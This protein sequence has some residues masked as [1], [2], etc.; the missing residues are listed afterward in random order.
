MIYDVVIGLSN[1]QDDNARVLHIGVDE[2]VPGLDIGFRLFFISDGDQ[3]GK[4]HNG[5]M[6]AC[7][8]TQR[9][10]ENISS[11]CRPDDRIT[12]VSDSH[13]RSSFGNDLREF[14]KD[15]DV[16]CEGNQLHP[17]IL[18]SQ[19]RWDSSICIKS[20]VCVRMVSVANLVHTPSFLGTGRPVMPSRTELFSAGSS[21]T[22]NQQAKDE[23]Q[24]IHIPKSVNP[25]SVA[26]LHLRK[27]HR[28]L[29]ERPLELCEWRRFDKIGEEAIA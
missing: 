6:E 20:S 14:I 21:S 25:R 8:T 24:Q 3:S 11:K 15:E 16:T 9:D 17:I 12:E 28:T 1:G 4:T 13:Q 27:F 10:P 26:V 2:V 7:L 22:G 5:E 18:R 23:K 29:G 19:W